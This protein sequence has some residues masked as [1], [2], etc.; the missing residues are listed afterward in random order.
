MLSM[1]RRTAYVS[2]C[3]LRINYAH[4]RSPLADMENVHLLAKIS[5]HLS[6]NTKDTHEDR[7]DMRRS[8]ALR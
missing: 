8:Y 5:H 6:K 3:Q 1:R 7:S 4:V 2:L